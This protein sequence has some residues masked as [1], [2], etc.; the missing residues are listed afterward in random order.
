MTQNN[1]SQL[2]AKI[3]QHLRDLSFQPHHTTPLGRRCFRLTGDNDAKVVVKIATHAQA[4][5][6][7]HK[8]AKILQHYALP[9]MPSF[10]GMVESFPF[11]AL[12]MNH[13]EGREVRAIDHSLILKNLQ[14]IHGAQ[15]VHCDLKPSNIL[16]SQTHDVTVLDWEF[17][18]K[19]GTDISDLERR[20]FSQGWTHPRLI[21]GHGKVSPELDHI[22]LER[23]LETNQQNLP[24]QR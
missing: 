2:K 9:Q 18:A 6:A 8:E 14:E 20:P 11:A 24:D 22:F 12:V 17:A 15:L 4:C 5:T 3:F 7:L 10:L 23:L 16:V 19:P 13:A 21:W 1:N